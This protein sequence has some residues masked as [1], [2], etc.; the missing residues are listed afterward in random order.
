MNGIHDMG[1]MHG[2]GP[3]LAEP[4]EPLFHEAW[5]RQVMG[6]LFPTMAAIGLSVDEFRHGIERMDPGHYLATSYYE[7]WFESMVRH[8][9]E[10]G[11]V[12]REELVTGVPASGSKATPALPHEAVGT[13]LATGGT[14]RLP[15][16]V[17]ARFK[18]GD[19]VRVRNINPTGHTRLPRY[20]RG[21]L[22]RVE[23]DH[24]VFWT[25]DTVA[26]GLGQHPQH[27]YSVSFTARELWGDESSAVDTTRIDLWDDYLEKAE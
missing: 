23:I 3:V 4:N 15:D 16:Q 6:M 8:L 19:R 11:L 17:A 5:E 24:G 14:A 9:T 1:G 27:V 12:T 26:H 22:G 10:K 20:A 2:M 18:P 13:M 7:H 21:K 25:P